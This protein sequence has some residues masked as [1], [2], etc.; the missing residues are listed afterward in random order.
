MELFY[1][2]YRTEVE[3]YPEDAIWYG[4]I[5][6]ISDLVNFQ[7]DTKDEIEKEFH[8][9]VDDYLDF[10]EEV[11]TEPKREY[12]GMS[13]V[14]IYPGLYK[15]L[16]DKAK[17]AGESFNEFIEKILSDYECRNTQATVGG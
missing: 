2:N 3:Y 8:D 1:K 5:E 11:G 15:A 13:E 14:K 17:K 16:A 12:D 9:A 7:S 6:G 10:C 4:R